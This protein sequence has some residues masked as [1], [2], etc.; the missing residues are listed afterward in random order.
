MGT[1]GSIMVSPIWVQIRQMH[2]GQSHCIVQDTMLGE[3]N[4]RHVDAPHGSDGAASELMKCGCGVLVHELEVG[5]IQ[6][7]Q[8]L[9]TRHSGFAFGS[10]AIGCTGCSG[11]VAAKIPSLSRPSATTT[12][13][14][15]WT[16]VRLND[17]RRWP[18]IKVAMYF[19]GLAV[20]TA[21]FRLIA[22][23]SS[24]LRHGNHATSVTHF[25]SPLLTV[26]TSCSRLLVRSSRP[27]S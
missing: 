11:R 22:L 4:S 14:I 24:Q 20:C 10:G 19:E 18:W 8:K 12:A 26:L 1:Q 13:R 17:D 25:D 5:N 27:F 9:H 3:S 23:H 6:T 16:T 2:G 7:R 15:G 21:G